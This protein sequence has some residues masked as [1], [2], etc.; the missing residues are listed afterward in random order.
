MTKRRKR[1]TKRRKTITLVQLGNS[2]SIPQIKQT[3]SSD[4]AANSVY[5]LPPIRLEPEGPQ[6]G[7]KLAESSKKEQV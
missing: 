4:A 2:T 6:D 7:R 3:A 5:T 1:I